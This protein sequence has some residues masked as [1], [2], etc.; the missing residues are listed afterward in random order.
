MSSFFFANQQR[1]SVRRGL[2]CEMWS[3]CDFSSM[4]LCCKFEVEPCCC[5]CY[6]CFCCCFCCRFVVVLLL[7]CLLLLSFFQVPIAISLQKW[8]RSL[9]CRILEG[10]GRDHT[11]EILG[12]SCIFSCDPQKSW[13][14]QHILFGGLQ[15]F[16]F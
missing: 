4:L 9:H 3:A 15:T 14:F 6:C 11:L 16:T 12:H 7:F 5:G 10:C 1:C 13:K 8:Q 2:L